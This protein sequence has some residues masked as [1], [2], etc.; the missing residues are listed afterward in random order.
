MHG[1]YYVIS[2]TCQLL[3]I[4]MRDREKVKGFFPLR[5]RANAGRGEGGGGHV[6]GHLFWL[7]TIPFLLIK[8]CL[9]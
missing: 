1:N 9:K 5:S 3:R 2:H 8:K 7:K 4:E 6:V